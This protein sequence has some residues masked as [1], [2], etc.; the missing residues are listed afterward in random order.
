MLETLSRITFKHTGFI[1]HPLT[2]IMRVMR[3]I[4]EIKITCQYLV[5]VMFISSCFIVKNQ[6]QNQMIVGKGYKKG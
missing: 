6:N 4:L 1:K 3:F 2:L 5:L